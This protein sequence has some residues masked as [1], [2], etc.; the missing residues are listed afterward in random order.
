[1]Y[2]SLKIRYSTCNTT[3]RRS[4]RSASG[5]SSNG[6]A[7]ALIRC[8]ARLM[9]WAIVVSGTK[10]APAICAVVNPPTAR[11]VSASCDAGESA[12]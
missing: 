12:G 8:F 1:M 6:T 9:R 11:N 2:P 7:L 5:G 4:A 3:C 10:N